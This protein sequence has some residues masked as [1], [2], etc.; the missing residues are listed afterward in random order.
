MIHLKVIWIPTTLTILSKCAYK[1]QLNNIIFKRFFTKTSTIWKKFPPKILHKKK[2]T[3]KELFVGG[4]FSKAPRRRIIHDVMPV[5]IEN[6]VTLFKKCH[7]Q[8]IKNQYSSCAFTKTTSALSSTTVSGTVTVAGA[9]ELSILEEEP[10]AI[11]ELYGRAS[12]QQTTGSISQNISRMYQ[13]ALSSWKSPGER[14]INY[15]KIGHGSI[16]E[17]GKFG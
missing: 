13:G 3:P 15:C 12:S 9:Q 11:E 17:S 8:I 10:N 7:E 6:A 14:R 1:N 4:L 5:G 16:C 2:T